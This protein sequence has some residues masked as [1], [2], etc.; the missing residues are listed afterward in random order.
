[1]GAELPDRDRLRD[2]MVADI[3]ASV[4]QRVAIIYNNDIGPIAPLLR[5]CSD[6]GTVAEM[7]CPD[8][9]SRAL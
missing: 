6:C 9:E 5:A 4:R 7:H 1:M 3:V 8:G 2:S